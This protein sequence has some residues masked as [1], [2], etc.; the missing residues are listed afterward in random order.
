MS[1]IRAYDGYM[2]EMVCERCAE[3]SVARVDP[4]GRQISAEVP[5][6]VLKILGE[7]GGKVVPGAVVMLL[8]SMKMEIPVL[9]EVDG[10]IS[11]ILVDVGDSV[12]ANAPVV[13]IHAVSVSADQ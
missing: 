6:V 10:V 7:V 4:D 8:E 2:S 11:R 9:S 12:R 5:G 3:G 1:S 13:K